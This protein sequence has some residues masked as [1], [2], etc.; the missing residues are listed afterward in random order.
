MAEHRRRW[1]DDRVR[2]QLYDL[3]DGH[4]ERKGRTGADCAEWCCCFAGCD[5]CVETN[6]RKMALSPEGKKP[7]VVAH[8]EIFAA[9]A[10]D[11]GDAQRIT[12][13]PTA[14]SDPLWSADSMKLLYRAD[15]GS[16]KGSGHNLVMYDFATSSERVLTK[17]G[18][19]DDGQQWS[20]DGKSVTYVREEKELHVLTIPVKKDAVVTGKVVATEAMPETV[21]TWSPDGQWIA[22]TADD[23]RSFRNVKCRGGGWR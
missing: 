18:N 9:S 16:G 2:A 7:A 15:A 6:F 12:D 13:T 22:Y 19:E 11:G 20:P 5:A 17:A 23:A 21:L 1:A 3:E 10:K 8:G 14:E 4:R